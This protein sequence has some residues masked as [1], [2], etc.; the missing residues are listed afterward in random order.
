MTARTEK[1]L[2]ELV[3]WYNR[4]GV[5]GNT[6]LHILVK[7]SRRHLDRLKKERRDA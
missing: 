5:K 6:R 7:Q 4:N 3:G 1:L 2:R